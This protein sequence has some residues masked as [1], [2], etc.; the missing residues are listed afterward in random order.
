MNRIDGRVT[1]LEKNF[2]RMKAAQRN[3]KSKYEDAWM[4]EAIETA[5]DI[6]VLL[7]I[8][9]KAGGKPNKEIEERIYNCFLK[10]GDT[11][12]KP[13]A[14]ASKPETAEEKP[15]KPASED[16]PSVGGARA[17]ICD[18]A[19]KSSKEC[20][21]AAAEEAA[22]KRRKEREEREKAEEAA[23]EAER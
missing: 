16:K 22:E 17:K 13:A 1:N 5:M 2:S 23:K 20:E 14:E 15:V 3:E 8:E 7:H 12:K 6:R 18:A 19:K 9:M 4:K 10:Y 21:E 11:G